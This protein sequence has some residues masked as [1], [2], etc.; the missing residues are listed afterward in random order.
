MPWLAAAVAVDFAGLAA[1]DGY[2]ASFTT[3]E[4]GKSL[5]Q[6]NPTLSRTLPT[7]VSCNASSAFKASVPAFSDMKQVCLQQSHELLPNDQL[8]LITVYARITLHQQLC[9]FAGFFFPNCGL[10]FAC[11]RCLCLQFSLVLRIISFN[12]NTPC[13]LSF[14][15]RRECWWGWRILLSGMSCF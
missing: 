6:N 9:V 15:H 12:S 2:M 8:T 3:P 13:S 5:C 4:K 11:S 10:G 1:V 7:S 14:L